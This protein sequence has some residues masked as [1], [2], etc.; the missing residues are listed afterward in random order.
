MRPLNA[1]IAEEDHT[2]GEDL[3]HSIQCHLPTPPPGPSDRRIASPCAVGSREPHLPLWAAA[4]SSFFFPFCDSWAI[5][6]ISYLGQSLMAMFVCLVWFCLAQP[7][8]AMSSCAASVQMWIY[9][10][11][12]RNNYLTGQMGILSKGYRRAT[13]HTSQ[14]P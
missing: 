5:L 10:G 11:R 4:E 14:G 3:T 8:T 12:C 6:I 1:C 2:S 7:W 9:I 13:S